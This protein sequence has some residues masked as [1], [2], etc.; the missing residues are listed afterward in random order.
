MKASQ[1]ADLQPVRQTVLLR[2][3]PA[4]RSQGQ[5]LPWLQPESGCPESSCGVFFPCSQGLC[6]IAWIESV[7]DGSHMHRAAA[8]HL[9]CWKVFHRCFLAPGLKFWPLLPM[10]FLPPLPPC[11]N[12]GYEAGVLG[13]RVQA[14]GLEACKRGLKRHQLQTSGAVGAACAKEYA[15]KCGP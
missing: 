6:Y 4:G 3:E 7:D 8:A 1:R 9:G 11:A 12:L 10:N 2:F 14:S 15:R 13:V 5:M